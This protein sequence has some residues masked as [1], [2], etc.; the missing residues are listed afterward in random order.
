MCGIIMMQ[1]TCDALPDTT[2][3]PFLLIYAMYCSCKPD[4]RHLELNVSWLSFPQLWPHAALSS[5]S[6]ALPLP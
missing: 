2:A 5:T 1:N 3:C 6:T 4:L